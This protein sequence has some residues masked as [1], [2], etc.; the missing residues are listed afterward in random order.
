MALR[1]ILR[2]LCEDGWENGSS[3]PLWPCHLPASVSLW[4]DCRVRVGRRQDGGK[5]VASFARP[6]PDRGPRQSLRQ[7]S[8]ASQK[9]GI[10]AMVSPTHQRENAQAD[11]RAFSGFPRQWRERLWGAARW[12]QRPGPLDAA[13]QGAQG[14][15]YSAR[16]PGAIDAAQPSAWAWAWAWPGDIGTPT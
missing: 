11:D 7:S 2:P 16:C 8:R 14:W 6:R 12:G 4:L 9:V 3:S 15:R 10:H 1:G 5:N 13:R